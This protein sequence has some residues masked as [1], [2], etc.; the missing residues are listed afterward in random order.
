MNG[1]LDAYIDDIKKTLSSHD[2]EFQK[3]VLEN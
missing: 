3:Q 1:K 2:D